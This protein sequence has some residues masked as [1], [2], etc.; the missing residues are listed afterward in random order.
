MQGVSLLILMAGVM[1]ENNVFLERGFFCVVSG[2][3]LT[4]GN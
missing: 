2:C 4:F 1:D 3:G